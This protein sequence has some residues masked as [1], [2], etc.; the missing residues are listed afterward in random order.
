MQRN[1]KKIEIAPG[2]TRY[3]VTITG[4]PCARDTVEGRKQQHAFINDLA[5]NP[6]L[7]HCGLNLFQ[8][9]VVTHNGECWMAEV[10]AEVAEGGYE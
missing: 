3:R 10:E 4:N 2:V 5:N 9:L 7:L 1:V 6:A 8:K